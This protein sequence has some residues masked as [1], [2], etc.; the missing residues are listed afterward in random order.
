[1]TPEEKKLVR[2]FNRADVRALR[3]IYD[4]Y[5][6]DLMTLATA[7]L[8]DGPSAEDAVHDVFARLAD[9]GKRIKIVGSLLGYLLTA[10]ANSARSMLRRVSRSPLMPDSETLVS[11]ASPDAA[12]SLAEARRDLAQALGE[13]PF[14]QREVLLLRYFGG[15]PFKAIAESQRV[16]INTVQGRHRYGLEKL[17]SLL[18]GAP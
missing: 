6:H 5:R 1:M 11:T 4:L 2:R 3:E 15:L 12:A 13:L 8:R 18:K 9:S 10:V 16:S 14:E 17:R 7:L